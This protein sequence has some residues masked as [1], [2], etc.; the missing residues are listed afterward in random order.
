M[1]NYEQFQDLELIIEPARRLERLKERYEEFRESMQK[2]QKKI[3]NNWCALVESEGESYLD[4]NIFKLEKSTNNNK[5]DGKIYVNFSSKFSGLLK[6]VKYLRSAGFSDEEIP[7]VAL[8]L[9]EQRNTFR[10][11]VRYLSEIAQVYNDILE[12]ISP[13]ET[14]LL[15]KQLSFL[16]DKMA[17]LGAEEI[18]WRHGSKIEKFYTELGQPLKDFQHRLTKS[19]E[20]LSTIKKLAYKWSTEP[21][22]KREGSKSCNLLDV[23]ETAVA[24]RN[25]RFEDLVS[26]SEEIQQLI[27]DN[28]ELLRDEGVTEDLWNLY[29]NAADEIVKGGLIKAAAISMG[30]LMDHTDSFLTP[31]VL[32]QVSM[33]LTDSELE[34]VPALQPEE[35]DSFYNQ[36]ESILEAIYHQGALIARV[37]QECNEDNYLIAVRQD[38]DLLDMQSELLERVTNVGNTSLEYTQRFE[39]YAYIYEDDREE[40]LSNFLKTGQHTHGPQP[41]KADNP[42]GE[43]DDPE[44]PATLD[45][46]RDAIDKF[47]LTFNEIEKFEPNIVLDRWFRLDMSSFKETLGNTVKEWGLMF[48]QHLMDSVVNGLNGLEEFINEAHAGL[49]QPLMDGDLPTLISVM[50]LLHRV[51]Q[52]SKATDEMFEP[53]KEYIDLLKTYDYELP[54]SVFVQL[55]ELPARWVDL[56]N[57]AKAV[58]VQ[59]GPMQANEVSSIRKRINEFDAKQTIFRDQFRNAGFFQ[60]NCAFPYDE[61]NCSELEVRHYEVEYEEICAAAKLFEVPVPDPKA[62]R[63]CRREIRLAKGLWDYM[64]MVDA[65]LADW[66]VSPWQGIDAE[67]MDTEC[68]RMAKEVK[69]MDKDVKQWQ[70]YFKLE[71]TIRNIISSLKTVSELQ[72]PSIKDRHWEELLGSTKIAPRLIPKLIDKFV[73]DSS[74]TFADLYSLGLHNFE[75]EVKNVVDKAVKESSMEKTLKELDDTWRAQVYQFEIHPRTGTKLIKTSEELIEVLEDN[76]VQLQNIAMSKY[77]SFFR[78]QVEFWQKR[79]QQADSVRPPLFFLK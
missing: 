12:S 31:S 39:Q 22:F 67:Y 5:T 3:F 57:L 55:E 61:L 40:H 23:E 56:K 1:I 32:M 17:L 6:E 37:S 2:Y 71:A 38:P 73:R 34:F 45:Q 29:L 20:N 79:L 47:E 58:K 76:Q 21:L 72:N 52:R 70:L 8:K 11:H 74:T 19:Q 77:I 43:D 53:I 36:M 16:R 50:S 66:K 69:A 75:E 42:Y 49:S 60:P 54:E 63:Q 10:K 30:Y 44:E 13:V 18:S 27:R 35:E 25:E 68:K 9:Y 65:T 62:L 51:K 28:E 59:A 26:I 48:K 78:E 46:F 15:A 33:Q 7:C 64:A 4:Q 41:P 24:S 14:Q